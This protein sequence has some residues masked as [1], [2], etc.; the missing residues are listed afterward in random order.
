MRMLRELELFVRAADAGSLSAAARQL[1][2]TPAA[3]SAAVKRIEAELG[4][5]V[6]V[7]STRSLRLTHAGEAFLRHCRQGL[8]AIA[9]GRD[10]VHSGGAAVRGVLQISLPSDFGRNVA[11][12]WLD[13]FLALHPQ[14][15][16]RLDISDR[17][18]DVFRQPVDI[19]LRYGTPPDSSL[20][21]LPVAPENRRVLCGSPD[22]VARQGAPRSPAE[23]A[24]H[25][26]L[27]FMAGEHIHDRWRFFR[28]ERETSIQVR[29]NRVAVDGDAVRLWAVAG[30]G[31]AYK[32][33][34]DVAQDLRAGRLL[35][36]CP[37]WAGEPAPL[38]LMLPG[39]SQLGPAVQ[40]LRTFLAARCAALLASLDGNGT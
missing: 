34:L 7:R 8:Q 21:A 19:A 10:A 27:C 37:E 12:P 35:R 38:N 30:H 2:L 29:G 25:N 1:D 36:L 23:L 28:D 14:V 18:A 31:V 15:Q 26:C 5:P 40:A 3:A 24:G 16:L 4:A 11:L 32:S 22:Y 6:F 13:E 9:D 39:R 33:S 17:I 20:V